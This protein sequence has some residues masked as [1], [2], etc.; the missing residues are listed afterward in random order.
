VLWRAI[1]I[2]FCAKA[3]ECLPGLAFLEQ[4]WHSNVSEAVYFTVFL[5]AAGFAAN[6]LMIAFL[7]RKDGPNAWRLLAAAFALSINS[8]SITM[9]FVR[10]AFYFTWM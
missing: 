3:A 6:L 8:Y 1:L 7:F 5:F 10:M 4:A 9:L 2:F